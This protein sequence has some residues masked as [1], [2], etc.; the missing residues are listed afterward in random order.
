MSFVEKF[1]KFKK[2]LKDEPVRR[3]QEKLAKG[4]DIAKFIG[5]AKL[6]EV[7][8]EKYSEGWERIFGSKKESPREPISGAS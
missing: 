7:D 5:N 3:R 1:E 2:N 4:A 8:Q 6:G